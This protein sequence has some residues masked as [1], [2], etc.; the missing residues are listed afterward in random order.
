M[1]FY[2]QVVELFQDEICGH[3]VSQILD[4]IDI[5]DNVD[6]LPTHVTLRRIR[7]VRFRFRPILVDGPGSRDNPID[8][9]GADR[10]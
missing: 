10:A 7:R 5:Q 1:S 3:F 8:L 4:L 2:P 6:L 9:T